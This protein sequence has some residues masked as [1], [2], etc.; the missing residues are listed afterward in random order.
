MERR[1]VLVTGYPGAGKSTLAAA[2]ASALG[3]PLIAKDQMLSTIFQAMGFE[4]GD[5]EGSL[6]SGNA[7]WALFWDFARTLPAAVLDSNIKPASA[8]ERAQVA[9]LDGRIVEVRCDCP[10]L[11]AQQRYAERAA[12]LPH[13]AAR[14]QELSS[15][16]LALYEGSLG[17]ARRVI[18]DTSQSWDLKPIAAEVRRRLA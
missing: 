16:R 2:L 11:L 4:A 1:I 18:V 13:P 9:N 3:F 15:E 8:F 12:H 14:T 6:R 17:I 10:P 7:A 5:H